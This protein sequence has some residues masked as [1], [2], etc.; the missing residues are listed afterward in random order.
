MSSAVFSTRYHGVGQTEVMNRLFSLLSTEEGSFLIWILSAALA[1][2][3][4]LQNETWALSYKFAGLSEH[5]LT[6][7]S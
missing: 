2:L 6:E 3:D 1:A 4:C 7:G 5:N